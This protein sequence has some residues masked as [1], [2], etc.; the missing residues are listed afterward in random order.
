MGLST[1]GDNDPALFQRV[2]RS[3]ALTDRQPEWETLPK[4]WRRRPL[5]YRREYELTW[6]ARA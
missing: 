2:A 3:R 5:E 1:T 6:K 4:I